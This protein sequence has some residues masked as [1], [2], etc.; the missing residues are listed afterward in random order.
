MH[1][2]PINHK[3]HIFRFMAYL[4]LLAGLMSC[5]EEIE[6]NTENFESLLV[7]EANI[8]NEM[9]PQEVNIS[10]TFRFEEEEPAKVSNATVILLAD[11]LEF[12]DFLETTPGKYVSN[13]AFAAQENVKYSLRVQTQS[14]KN[15][16]S[17]TSELVGTAEIDAISA[18]ASEDSLGN[19]GVS[20][21]ISSSTSSANGNYYKYEYAETYKIIAPFW[22]SDD[23]VPE[24]NQEIETCDFTIEL[25]E[26]EERVCYNT[27][28][29]IGI[30]LANSIGLSQGQL[31]DFEVR[32]ID[33]DNTIIAHRYSM[34]L[35]QFVI[36]EEAHSYF[37]K[38]KELS[39]SDNLFSQTQPGFLEGN[40]SALESP[41][42]ERVIGMF[43]VSSVSKKR[44]YFNWSDLFP[45]TEPPQIPCGIFAP[46]LF[47]MSGDC[48]LKE[49]VVANTVRYWEQNDDQ[50]MNE[51]PYDVVSRE[52]GDCTARGSNV[53]PEF[54]EE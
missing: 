21:L 12:A 54:W 20:V 10:R 6:L 44:F 33:L 53:V 25:R 42:T 17:T 28:Q 46:P 24:E 39:S 49:S 7:I 51:G 8:T 30:I 23:L 45:E 2:T 5:V 15:Y 50:G 36:P 16:V 13:F 37:E 40:I 41:D 31:D 27:T 1:S 43:Y 11:G 22:R 34:L 32:F 9:K 18:E 47:K 14:G 48:L 4:C 52:C 26:Q 35:K 29:S 38:R 3:N 19:P